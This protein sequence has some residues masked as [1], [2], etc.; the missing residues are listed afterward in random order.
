MSPGHNRDNSLLF[1]A[2]VSLQIICVD[3]GSCLSRNVS[4]KM[5][6][7]RGRLLLNEGMY[8]ELLHLKPSPL[9]SLCKYL[10]TS[11]RLLQYVNVL[12]AKFKKATATP[13]FLF[14][15]EMCFHKS[16]HIQRY[17]LLV[18]VATIHQL[19]D[20]FCVVRTQGLHG[21]VQNT[22]GVSCER[23]GLS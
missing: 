3:R 1:W 4:L 18:K 20:I 19:M 6:I 2:C 15:Y 14:R 16:R 12:P 5:R 10:G 9:L 17:S 11:Q 23:L 8:K 22:C 13:D 21:D 7:W